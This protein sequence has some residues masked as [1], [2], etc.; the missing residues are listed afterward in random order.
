MWTFSDISVSSLALAPGIPSQS[1]LENQVDLFEAISCSLW[2][3]GIDKD[4]G[5]G[6]REDTV[7]RPISPAATVMKENTHLPNA[8]AAPATWRYFNGAIFNQESRISIVSD[9]A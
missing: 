2:A 6:A 3:H 9:L 1:V 8:G 7:W 5:Y 4:Y